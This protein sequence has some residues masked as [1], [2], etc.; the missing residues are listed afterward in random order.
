MAAILFSAWKH[1]ETPGNIVETYGNKM[2]TYGNIVET[3]NGDPAKRGSE[4]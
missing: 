1:M 4:E 2:E 3:V